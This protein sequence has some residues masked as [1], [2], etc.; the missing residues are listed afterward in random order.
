MDGFLR[1]VP[2]ACRGKIKVDI[3]MWLGRDMSGVE[4]GAQGGLQAMRNVSRQ[5]RV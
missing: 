5:R 3:A 4:A 1:E 2:C